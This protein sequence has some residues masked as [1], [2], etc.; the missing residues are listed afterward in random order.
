MEINSIFFFNV[1]TG[2]YKIMLMAPIT[3]LLD[4]AA[5]KVLETFEVFVFFD[6]WFLPVCDTVPMPVFSHAT[7]FS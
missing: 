2:K 1:S 7:K 3:F 6:T 5:S 4:T